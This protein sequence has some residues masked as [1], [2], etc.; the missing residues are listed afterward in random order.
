[1]K[2]EQLRLAGRSPALPMSVA[3]GPD[4]L[5]VEQWLRVLPGQRYVARAHWQG[6]RV[7]AKLV[8]GER[9]RRH[10]DRE[11]SGAKLLAEQQ[12]ATPRLLD[13]GYDEKG[14]WLLFEYLDDAQSLHDAW[15]EVADQKP[16]SHS[17]RDVLS[18][19]LAEVA[20]LHAHGL[21]QS[22]LHLDNLMRRQ[23]RLYL[24]DGGGVRAEHTGKPLSRDIVLDNLALFFA[25]LPRT[26]EPFI[27]EL[28]VSYLLVNDANALPVEALLSKIE[29]ARRRRLTDYLRKIGRDCTAFSVRRDRNGLVA[30]RRERQA[31]LA[32]LLMAP[33]R[34]VSDGV[35]LKQGAS[36]TV[37]R[38]DVDG[39]PLVVKRYNIKG[40]AHWL[41]RCWR[42][43]RAWH[44]W[45]EGHRLILS[46][47]ATPQ[48]LA[49]IETRRLGLR[50]R[51]FLITEYVAGQDII[52][53][54]GP[55]MDGAPPE[56]ELQA[57]EQLLQALIRERISHGDLKGTN[58]LW[59]DDR[60]VLIDLDA[61]HQ[62]R[63]FETFRQAFA[64]D[65]ARLLRNWPVDSALY[66]LLDQRLPK[67]T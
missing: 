34:F 42:P 67:A 29:A 39:S 27:E 36:A 58:L 63:G 8:V 49:V 57:L 37:A 61:L 22:D 13:H 2:L 56:H 60:W 11:L 28:L 52:A 30:V 46:G 38:I 1:M 62:H 12:L 53:R 16:L 32:A 24:I 55:Y 41:K 14:G 31:Q 43:S 33:D 17:Q 25:Q 19:A 54:F 35:S 9:A 48:P 47:I 15:L 50:S 7:L 21:W 18:S 66:R 65:R 44:S 59:Q 40:L 45:V 64:K 10:F 5:H 23:Q 6:R 51:S 20:R 3:L 4:N 26:L